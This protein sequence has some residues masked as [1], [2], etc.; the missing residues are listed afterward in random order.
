MILSKLE[1]I[2]NEYLKQEEDYNYFSALILRIKILIHLGKYQN[3]LEELNSEVFVNHCKKNPYFEGERLYFMGIISSSSNGIEGLKPAI[4]YFLKA[5]DIIKDLL[6]TELTWRVLFALTV[7]YAERGN[8]NR[9][10]SFLIYTKAVLDYISE[11]IPDPRL[12]LLYSDQPERH[13]ALSTLNKL[14]EKL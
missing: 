14:T 1:K 5:Y 8:S 11:K 13:A 10:K 4:E 3:G 9:A 6:V 2:L 12:K 7:N